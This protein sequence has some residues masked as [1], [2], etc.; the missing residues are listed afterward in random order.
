MEA[1]V[2]RVAVRDRET[3]VLDRAAIERRARRLLDDVDLVLGSTVRDDSTPAGVALRDAVERELRGFHADV[4]EQ[5]RPALEGSRS[6]PVGVRR[7]AQF[8]L[9]AAVLRVTGSDALWYTP[10]SPSR[11]SA[12]ATSTR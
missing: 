8:V 2:I 11:P 10:W 9:R 12:T 4:R 7:V 6:A 5:L 1:H 3:G